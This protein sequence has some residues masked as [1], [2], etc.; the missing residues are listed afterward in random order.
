M[1]SF[2]IYYIYLA[3]S[4]ADLDMRKINVG[5]QK[6]KTIQKSLSIEISKRTTLLHK[7]C[8]LSTIGAIINGICRNM[9]PLPPQ[10]M[11][12]LSFLAGI[13]SISFLS[14]PTLFEGE[15]EGGHIYAN[16]S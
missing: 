4:V 14:V 3:L 6:K 5:M 2:K 13:L 12:K 1:E 10:T 7:F 15:G 16:S 9:I 11:L 8:A